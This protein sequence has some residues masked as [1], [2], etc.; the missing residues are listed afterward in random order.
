MTR[1]PRYTGR[2]DRILLASDPPGGNRSPPRQ[3]PA[4]TPCSGCRQINA[5]SART[6]FATI[7]LD[8]GRQRDDSGPISDD[9]AC[10]ATQTYP[11]KRATM[12]GNGGH[13]PPDHH[14]C[15]WP[16]DRTRTLRAATM[17]RRLFEMACVRHAWH[18]RTPHR[19]QTVS[20][21]RRSTP[22][23]TNPRQAAACRS[24]AWSSP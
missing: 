8:A 12:H 3:C 23:P 22:Y 2:R 15:S 1:R 19:H 14:R 10:P 5:T 24:P 6:M 18:G 4:A 7:A 9:V 21:S 13:L 11:G 17:P 20:P 16:Y